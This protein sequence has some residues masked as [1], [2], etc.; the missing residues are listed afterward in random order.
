MLTRRELESLLGCPLTD[1]QWKENC[2]ILDE[3]LDSEWENT[4]PLD[5]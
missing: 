3:I 5:D 2:R 1:E 4:H